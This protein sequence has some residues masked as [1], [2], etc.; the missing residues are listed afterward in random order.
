MKASACI[1][2][3]AR[4]ELINENDLYTAL[5]NGLLTGFA[6]DTLI[7]EPPPTSHPLLSLPNVVLTPHCGAYTSEA[8]SRAS[9]IAAQEVVRVLSGEAPLYSVSETAAKQ[10]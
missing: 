3:T 8:V 4:G 10:G 9:M 5:K 2:N 1:I 6:A 7:Q